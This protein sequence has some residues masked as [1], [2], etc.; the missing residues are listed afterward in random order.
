MDI[1]SISDFDTALDLTTLISFSYSYTA[2]QQA[3]KWDPL[4]VKAAYDF[5]R[6]FGLVA[7]GG[8]G[9][10][11]HDDEHFTSVTATKDGITMTN[12][13]EMPISL[14]VRTCNEKNADICKVVAI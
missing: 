6:A 10:G 1:S 13:R 3:G 2:R 14:Y 7:V 11:G 12:L 4:R 8:Y 5:G 9:I